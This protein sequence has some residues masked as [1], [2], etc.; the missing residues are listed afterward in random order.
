M[1]EF[2]F[3]YFKCKTLTEEQSEQLNYS[4]MVCDQQLRRLN[5][6]AQLLND[7]EQY[8]EAHACLAK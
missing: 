3:F 4:L 1:I 8:D 5:V 6:E 2:A 7:Y